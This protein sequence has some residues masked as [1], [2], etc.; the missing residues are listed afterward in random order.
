VRDLRFRL[1]DIERL[2]GGKLQTHLRGFDF[3]IVNSLEPRENLNRIKDLSLPIVGVMHNANLIVTDREYAEFFSSDAHQALV[4]ASHISDFMSKTSRTRWIS[5]VELGTVEH[6]RVAADRPTV[7]CVQGNVAYDRRNYDSLLD[8]VGRLSSTGVKN[9]RIQIIGRNDSPDG[10]KLKKDIASQGHDQFFQ[11]SQG[12]LD[13]RNYYGSIARTDFMLPLVDWNST[14][15]QAYFKDKLSTSMQTALAFGVIPIVH[16]DLA[17]LYGVTDESFT[18]SDDVEDAM[19]RA[20]RAS[21]DELC[22]MRRGL[23]QKR[24]ELLERSKDN[25]KLLLED[26]ALL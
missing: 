14:D 16:A 13:Y 6:G 26:L 24:A 7:F 11:F 12:E 22:A 17:E 10:E 1:R 5:P 15:H 4:M 18:Y 9:F 3:L 25:L 20:I 21:E 8:A 23:A 2:S 19:I